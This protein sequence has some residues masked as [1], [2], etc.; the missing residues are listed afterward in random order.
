MKP[1]FASFLVLA[2]CGGSPLDPGA[3]NS[4]GTGTS[5]LLVDGNARAHAQISN[6]KSSTDFTTE[7]SVQVTLNNAPVTTGTVEVKSSKLTTPLTFNPNGQN[8][9]QGGRW[10][11]TAAGYDEAYELNVIS[12]TDKVMG[13]IVDGPDIHLF[14]APMA[15]ASLDS[16]IA[17][18]MKW[19]RAAA[20]DIATL[21][22]GDL[23]HV[24]IA[25]TGTF[26]IPPG[27]LKAEK[28]QSH[29]NQ[30]IL[31]RE[32]HVAPKGAVAGST[33]SVSVDNE[34]DVIAL[35]N[36]AL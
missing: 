17:N 25:D 14:T 10:E 29:P 1:I 19:S 15:G 3:G 27:S 6:A 24:T 4:L 31:S 5:T 12:G 20:A 22:I 13:V 32:N 11:G 35:P 36:P 21:K 26:S 30:L 7:F 34:L 8:G 28:D 16:T 9:G 18:D 33:F 23:D 2:A